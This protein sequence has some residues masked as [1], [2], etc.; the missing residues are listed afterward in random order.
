MDLRQL[1]MFV[2]VAENLSFTI[3]GRRLHVAQSAISRQ[4]GLLEFELGEK[5]FKRVNRR[6][7]LTPAGET[8]LRHAR[9]VFQELR[10]ARLEISETANLHRGTIRLGAGL[11]ACMYL[12]PPVLER[13]RSLYP[14]IELQVVTGPTE[15]LLPQ[16]RDN[17]IDLGVFTLP[18]SLP[19][20]EVTPLCV[21]EI[22]AVCSPKHRA[23]AERR[24]I[25]ARELADYP[26]ILFGK[27]AAT[28]KVLDAFFRDIG[29]HPRIVMEAENV[30]VIKP[31]VAI[32]LGITLLPER[33]VEAEIR[34][35]ELHGLRIEDYPLKREIGLVYQKTDQLPKVLAV[36]IHLFR[37]H[38]RAL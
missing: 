1:E 2:A 10:N 22:I 38:L 19:G 27:G 9:R 18:A 32:D 25:P 11:T 33:A 15:S 26:L 37:R 34:R 5:L 13:F 4:I 30:A 12:I 14:N 36:L 24:S 21:E 29:V 16:I 20:L 7:Y 3:A 23:L 31:L 35:H 8:L 6:V 17:L 28:R